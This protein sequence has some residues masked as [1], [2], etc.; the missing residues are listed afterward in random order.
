MGVTMRGTRIALACA[1]IIVLLGLSI[2]LPERGSG[3]PQLK[4][5]PPPGYQS[6]ANA[7]AGFTGNMMRHHPQ[8]ACHYSMP[9][10]QGICA[11]ALEAMYL[12]GAKITGTWAV[13]HVV[14]A[15]DRAIVDVE[16][17]ACLGS[18][19]VTNTNPDA[20]LPDSGA[21]FNSAFRHALTDFDYAMDCVR[22][23]HGWYV[24]NVSD[25]V[26]STLAGSDRQAGHG[27]TGRLR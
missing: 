1:A 18:D 19:C 17:E 3:E 21:S 14:M 11:M 27:I 22:L 7:V 13:G 16:Y 2:W 25:A 12:L 8:A 6:P 23:P 10:R 4:P 5:P 24:D 20:G 15:G 26:P 9:A